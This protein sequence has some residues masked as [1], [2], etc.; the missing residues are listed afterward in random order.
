M[1]DLMMSNGGTFVDRH[2]IANVPTPRP[3]TTWRPVP[4]IDVIDAVSDV[5]K[6]HRWN[7]L[8]EQYGLASDGAKMFGIVK[9]SKTSSPD[10]SRCIGIRNS[11]D[12]SFAVGLTAGISV[13]VCSNLC[14]GGGMVLKR[15]HTSRIDLTELVDRA[16]EELESEFL[17]LETVC[18]DLKLFFVREDDARSRIVLAAEAGAIP[19]CDILQVYNAF[20]T[21]RHEDFNDPTRWSLLNA[22][23][24]VAHKYTPNRADLCYRRLTELFG[25]N[26]KQA[27]LWA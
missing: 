26:G 22:F 11:H 14:F 10:W 4:H 8:D 19:S 7:I 2:A 6:A 9:I 21:P 20:K 15:R 27:R 25:L 17:T 24:E 5:V 1:P 3:T 18:E 13:L 23:T 12:Q 16:V